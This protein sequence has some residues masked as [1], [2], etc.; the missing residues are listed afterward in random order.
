MDKNMFL[1]A[2]FSNQSC[3]STANLKGIT[4][5]LLKISR[6]LVVAR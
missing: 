1:A 6:R 5:G 2:L 4:E 3:S